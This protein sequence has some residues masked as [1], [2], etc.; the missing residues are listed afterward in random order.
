MKLSKETALPALVFILVVSTGLGIRYWRANN[1][2]TPP[3]V[4]TQGERKE[5]PNGKTSNE[6][7]AEEAERREN[8]VGK[9]FF[10]LL[11]GVGD[12]RNSDDNLRDLTYSCSDIL[13]VKA[14]LTEE[15][16]VP[17]ENIR[18][19]LTT[20]AEGSSLRPTRENI[21]V[22]LK[23]L[24]ETSQTD[25]TVMVMFTGHGFETKKGEAAF[26]P[27][28]VA[29]DAKGVKAE[30]TVLASDV[31]RRLQADDAKIKMLIVDACRS[32]APLAGKAQARPTFARFDTSGLAFLQSCGVGE[33]SYESPELGGGVFTHFFVE[34]LRGGSREADGRA[35]FWGVGGY[36][37]ERTSAYVRKRRDEEAGN[38]EAERRLTTPQT[39]F[40]TMNGYA[41]FNLRA[42]DSELL[43]REGRALA[44]GLDGTVIDGKRGFELL[45]KAANAG[46]LDA[47]AELALLYYRGGAAVEPDA[48]RAFGLATA[49]AEA[50]NPFA[51]Y[52]LGDCYNSGRGVDRDE[53]KAEALYKAAADELKKRADEKDALA[54][55]Y[56]GEK[57]ACGDGVEIDFRKAF[58]FFR[59]ASDLNCAIGKANLATCWMNGWGVAVD[60]AEA[61][62]LLQEARDQ[63]HAAALKGL[64]DCYMLGWD[65]EQNYDEAFRAFEAAAAQNYPEAVEMLGYCR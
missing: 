17:E 54:L 19:L 39:P 28:E 4:A 6:E 41:N 30:T 47:Q 25:S 36:A 57:Y 35:S 50:G 27:E 7:T 15:I 64:G 20:E 34:G 29:L 56:C 8:V 62:R 63:N 1:A 38:E 23:W 12:Y 45:T 49:P 58:E 60:Y 32:T 33:S 61:V 52:V 44:F 22:G 10:A 48:E 5:T 40:Y 2:S 3:N 43:Y 24:A 11:V 55:D 16:G 31:S 65:V 13:K 21:E 26:A 53:E 46:S 42:P 59:K 18:T 9:N 14:A 37:A 51:L